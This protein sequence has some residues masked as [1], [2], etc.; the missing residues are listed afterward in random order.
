MGWARIGKRAMGLMVMFWAIG[1][2]LSF[3]SGGT[4]ISTAMTSPI[5]EVMAGIG[6]ALGLFEGME[7]EESN[8]N[9]SAQH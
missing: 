4:T 3:I 5:S 1:I 8:G 9:G 6:F 2:V 7:S